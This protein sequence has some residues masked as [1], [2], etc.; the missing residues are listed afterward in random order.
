M[1]KWVK[2]C[3]V[4]E[5]PGA[6]EVSEMD[7]AGLALCVANIAGR[8][9]AIDNW[10]PHQRGPLGQGWL[11]G[12]AVICPLH[13]WAIDMFSGEVLPPDCGNIAVFPVK[14]EADQI[15]VDIG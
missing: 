8:F 10:C 2:L 13:S 6:G 3:S 5:A 12:N 11:E 15:L 1:S 4:Q 7:V 14:R 9:A